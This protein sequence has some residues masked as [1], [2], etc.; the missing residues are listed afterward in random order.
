MAERGPPA[1]APAALIFSWYIPD[2]EYPRTL[3]IGN[4]IHQAELD[5][6]SVEGGCKTPVIGQGGE[7]GIGHAISKKQDDLVRRPHVEWHDGAAGDR[8]LL[9]GSNPHRENL[10]VLCR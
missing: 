2:T 1:K 4:K 6:K 9:N 3:S 10:A 7:F 5:R 8:K